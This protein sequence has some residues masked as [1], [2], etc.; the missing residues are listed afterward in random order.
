MP[1]TSWMIE[2][3]H[4]R[5][6]L[7]HGEADAD[8][9]ILFE[10]ETTSAHYTLFL[11]RA[12]GFENP[13]EALLVSTPGLDRVIDLQERAKANLIAS[14]L[15]GLGLRPAQIAG[16][17]QCLGVPQFR[18]IAEALGWMYVTE[19]NTLVHTVVRRHLETRIS[20]SQSYLRAYEGTV[21]ARWKAFGVVLDACA[22]EP[23]IADRILDAA[24][25]AFRC[26]R[27]W[28]TQDRAPSMRAAS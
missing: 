6:H 28:I 16:L 18:G 12:F 13:L 2:R 14:D 8:F 21:G 5:T 9:D 27:R 15:L 24:G 23:V 4:A 3:L 22:V 10:R 7:Y 1:S 25:E 19:R 11:A 20:H 17:P 26:Q